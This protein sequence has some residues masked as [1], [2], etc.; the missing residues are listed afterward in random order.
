M[1]ALTNNRTATALIA[2][3]QLRVVD[4]NF[5]GGHL[6]QLTRTLN[7]SGVT[8]LL[9]GRVM[10]ETSAALDSGQNASRA[11]FRGK[12]NKI[13]LFFRNSDVV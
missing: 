13:V 4:L 3:A 8:R 2:I 5:M 12:R 9:P 11:F 6:A 10:I 7:V 1:P